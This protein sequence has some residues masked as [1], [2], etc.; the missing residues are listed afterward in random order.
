MRIIARKTLRE[1]WEKHPDAR[2]VLQA[3][4]ADVKHA[5]WKSPAD[6]KNIYRNASFLSNNRVVFN[7]KGN[8][9]RLIVSIQYDYGIVYIR[10]VGSHQEYDQVDASKNLIEVPL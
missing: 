6:I 1:F 9:Y 4:Y 10:F 8:R 3:W 2:Q 7:I 5:N